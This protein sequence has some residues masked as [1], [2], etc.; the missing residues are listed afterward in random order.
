M[1]NLW[2]C[3]ASSC[4]GSYR[5]AGVGPKEGRIVSQKTFDSGLVDFPV[6]DFKS[7]V[8]FLLR[9]KIVFLDALS[10][11]E[12]YL[13]LSCPKSLLAYDKGLLAVTKDAFFISSFDGTTKKIPFSEEIASILPNGLLHMSVSKDRKLYGISGETVVCIDM[14]KWIV[15]WS[16]NL[17]SK[18]G[19]SGN[20]HFVL[21][22][23]NRLFVGSAISWLGDEGPE[24]AGYLIAFSP[25]G[26][27]LWQ[28]NRDLDSLPTANGMKL[29][30]AAYGKRLWFSEDGVVVYD[31]DGNEVWRDWS[32]DESV[33]LMAINSKNSILFMKSD[34]ICSLSPDIADDYS[35]DFLTSINGAFI[36]AGVDSEDNIYVLTTEGLFAF[37]SKGKQI[38]SLPGLTGERICIGKSFMAVSS[39]AG[40]ITLIV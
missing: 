28:R 2:S 13:E 22:D 25:F 30:M 15:V 24:Y 35:M 1:E 10:G 7:R 27:L 16:E 11:E 34:E 19:Y 6:I 9:N 8:A 29:R 39:K 4:F 14:D 32:M 5:S 17:T 21:D 36:D 18:F 38:F 40:K 12:D 20:W 33:S 37:N 26:E 3:E 23:E 31:F